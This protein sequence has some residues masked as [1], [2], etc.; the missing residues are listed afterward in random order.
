VRRRDDVAVRIRES[1]GEDNPLRRNDFAVD[2]GAPVVLPFGRAHAVEVGAAHAQ[3]HPADR[4]REAFRPPPTLDE[5]RRGPCLPDQIAGD[6]ETAY[7]DQFLIFH[8]SSPFKPAIDLFLVPDSILHT[9]H[10]QIIKQTEVTK[11]AF[12][13][14]FATKSELGYALVDEILREMILERWVRPLAAYKN[15][16]QGILKR[17]K[18]LSEAM[19]E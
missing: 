9:I 2:S 16:L 8:L 11:G 19:T 6:V 4:G 18:V 1:I 5:L 17:F 13:H 14:H 10:D 7:D 15:P 3:I 12:F